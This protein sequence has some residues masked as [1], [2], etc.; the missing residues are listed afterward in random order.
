M[1][2]LRNKKNNFQLRALI[3][4]PYYRHYPVAGIINVIIIA[5]K[6]KIEIM[7]VCLLETPK[8]EH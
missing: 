4:R 7:N 5:H 3:W 8:Q 6:N 1:F 2:W